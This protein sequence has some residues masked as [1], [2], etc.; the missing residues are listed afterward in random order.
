MIYL[1]HEQLY[2]LDKLS[3]KKSTSHPRFNPPQSQWLL[4]HPLN[5]DIQRVSKHFYGH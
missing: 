5:F 3:K 1:I 2:F 4:L